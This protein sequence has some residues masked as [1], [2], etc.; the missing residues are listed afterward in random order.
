M[1]R[2]YVRVETHPRKGVVGYGVYDCVGGMES[3]H[4]YY[5]V[6]DEQPAAVALHLANADRDD[7]N[8]KIA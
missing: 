6:T 5:E 8:A 2:Y 3:Q 4:A 7:R 1:N